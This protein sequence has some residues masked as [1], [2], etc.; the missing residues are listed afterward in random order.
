MK[1][2]IKKFFSYN[3]CLVIVISFIIIILYGALLRS[4]YLGR[5]HFKY[6]QNFA[7]FLA[8]VPALVKNALISKSI[9]ID[10][11]VKD[12]KHIKKPR[13]TVFNEIDRDFLIVL[14]RYDY[15]LK[16]SVID[17]IDA[18]T[19]EVI[20][21]YKHDINE[22]INLITNLEEFP[23][24]HI[25][26]APHR[27][28]YYHPLVLD[29]GSLI[30][31][32]NGGP[33]FKIDYCSNL[34]FLNDEEVFH[35][36]INI[37]HKSNIWVGGRMGPKSFYV[38]KLGLDQFIDD[39]IVKLN[40]DGKI[41][42]KKSIVEI[43]IENNLVDMNIF[44]SG[45]DPI[46]LNDIEP[47]LNDTKYWN[48]G[49]LF[50]SIRGQSAI[51]HYRPQNNTVINY[52]KGPFS[53]QHDVDI[54]S[55]NEISIFNNNISVDY[56]KNNSYVLIYNF[57]NNQFKKILNKQLQNE[58]FFT[59]TSGLKH[60]LNNQ[61]ILEESNHGRLISFD[62]SGSKSWEFINKDKNSNISTI[63]WSR[64]ISDRTLIKKFRSGYFKKNKCKNR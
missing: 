43:L 42:F 2:K 11:P 62:N 31:H 36:S 41:L 40:L 37:D 6:L 15:S 39:S 20:H 22:L 59:E 44:K 57:E 10:T 45:N 3:V 54:L 46:H 53:L 27:F 18:K 25:D 34:L 17:I 7:V 14:S 50:I 24:F 52:I 60:F 28:I 26:K 35:H 23:K 38:N 51:I 58:N 13:I 8:S 64:I 21:S 29:D 55:K 47:A 49:D 9:V 30:S 16:R 32:P 1:K 19:F 63:F 12:D 33:L 61:L 56:D 48:K 4:H 5:D